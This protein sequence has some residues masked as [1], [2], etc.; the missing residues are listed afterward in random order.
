MTCHPEAMLAQRYLEIRDASNF[1]CA[2]PLAVGPQRIRT[3][4]IRRSYIKPNLAN[5]I[6]ESR[7]M[8][9]SGRAFGAP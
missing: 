5:A 8:A 2:L 3:A 9:T 1:V 4:L 6:R 7:S